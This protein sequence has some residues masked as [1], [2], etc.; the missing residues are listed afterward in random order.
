MRT[1]P[2]YNSWLFLIGETDPHLGVGPWRYLLVFLF[3]SLIVASV[4]IAY[5]NWKSD[6][7]QRTLRD[8]GT[9]AARVAGRSL[10]LDAILR[11]LPA[12]AKSDGLIA[13]LYRLAS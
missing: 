6:P 13:R 12:V 9:W 10:G 4:V 2:F 5:R 11:R 3:W 8:L 1:N 7:A